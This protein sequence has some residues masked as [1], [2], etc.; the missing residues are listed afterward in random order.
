MST[1]WPTTPAPAFRPTADVATALS[2]PW[3]CRKRM[4]RAMPP[5]PRP[6]ATL[7]ANDEAT[8][9]PAVGD[10]RDRA[11]NAAGQRDRGGQVGR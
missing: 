1:T 6:G 8:S 3:R 10:E 2:T 5:G 11:G 9:A 4:L 7:L